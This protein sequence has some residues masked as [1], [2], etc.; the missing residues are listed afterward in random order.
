MHAEDRE[1]TSAEAPNEESTG[2]QGPET[3]VRAAAEAPA[4]APVDAVPEAGRGAPAPDAPAEPSFVYALGLIEPRFPSP[5][6]EKEFAQASARIDTTG[7][8][9]RQVFHRVINESHNRYLVRQLCW[10][11]VVQGLETYILLPRDP[12]DYQLLIDSYPEYLTGEEI[13]LVVGLR[14]QIAPPEMCNGL[15]LPIVAFDQIYSFT[16]KT[17]LDA[18]PKPDS[19]TQKNE[20]KFRETAAG[21]LNNVRQ[22]ADNAGA[23][24]EHRALNYL[25]VRYPTIY[26]RA[27][28]AQDGNQSLSGVDVRMSPLSGVRKVV[29]V[30]F[31]YVHRQTDVM[32]RYL[33]RV[34][35]TEEYP[36]LVTPLCPYFEN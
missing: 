29:D 12:A 34:D 11:F 7:L 19:V 15:A 3:A 36:F 31:S 33:V 28:E 21:L 26:A 1:V 13:D 4:R 9:D 25:S 5:G 6:V 32:D 24:D 23:T 2:R 30:V 35:V 8:N 14:A 27:A 20:A 17:L 10:L 16:R 18:V 22:I